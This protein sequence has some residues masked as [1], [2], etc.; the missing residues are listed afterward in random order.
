[1]IPDNYECD[2]QMNLLDFTNAHTLQVLKKIK[3]DIE[4]KKD[5]ATTNLAQYTYENCLNVIEKAI[6]DENK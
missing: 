2:G 6:E 3:A 1:M 4:W 5:H